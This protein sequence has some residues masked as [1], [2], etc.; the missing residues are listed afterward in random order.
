MEKK[1]TIEQEAWALS[2]LSVELGKISDERMIDVA[3][4]LLVAVQAFRRAYEQSKYDSWS[5]GVPQFHKA[6]AMADAAIEKALR[7]MTA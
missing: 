4:D 6:E 5:E 2:H 7:V 1:E 3:R